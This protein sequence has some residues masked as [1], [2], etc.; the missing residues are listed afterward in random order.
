MTVSRAD[1]FTQLNKKQEYFSDFLNNFDR[2][3]ITN[4]LVRTTNEDSVKQA[5]KNLI[6]TNIGERV[7][8]PTVGSYIRASLFEPNDV[9]TSEKII[10]TI[11]NVVKFN[12]PRVQLL[13]IVANPNVENDS[14]DVS[15]VFAII[16]NPNPVTL[17][18]ILR[19]VR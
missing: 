6:L 19:R 13:N 9:I 18:L 17:N 16:N 8:Q 12:E 5:L 3:P 14:F 11:N 1:K 2:H 7:F 15:I 4:S 10:T